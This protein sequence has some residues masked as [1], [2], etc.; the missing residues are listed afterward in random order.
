[1][2]KIAIVNRTNLKNYGSVLQVYALCRAVTNLG[3]NSEVVWESGN[4]SKNFDFRPM[5]IISSLWKVLT[6]P[7]LWKRTLTNAKDM[8][9]RVITEKTAVLFDNFVKEE[10]IQNF[11]SSKQLKKIAKTNE[12]KKFICGS[13]QI[14]CSTTLY[15]DPLMYLRF[16]PKEKRIAYAPSIGRN[17]IPSYNKRVMKKYISQIPCVSIRE[18]DGKKLVKDLTGRDVP[19]VADPTLLLDKSEWDKLKTTYNGNKKYLL[20]YFLDVPS[21]KTQQKIIK[22]AKDNNLLIISLGFSLP[23]CEKECEVLYPDCGPREFLGYIESSECVITDSYHGMLF[24]IIYN[25][26]FF[27]IKREYKVYDQ[28][29]RQ[30]TIIDRLGLQERYIVSEIEDISLDKKIDYNL[31]VEKLQEFRDISLKYLKNSIEN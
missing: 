14:W 7:S 24:S 11:Y 26:Q 10:F 3:Y 21:E 25:K 16:C 27:E 20:C 22:V 12:Y 31:V 30:Q 28:S 18:D 8:N 13:D 17:Y 6:H 23:F 19:V 5:K 1:M 4:I 15:V 2:S 29:S 9:A